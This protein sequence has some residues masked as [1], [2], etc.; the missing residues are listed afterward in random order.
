CQGSHCVDHPAAQVGLNAAVIGE[1]IGS[2]VTGVAG[3]V[4]TAGKWVGKKVFSAAWEGVKSAAKS[5]WNW[6]KGLFKRD[7]KKAAGGSAKEGIYEFNGQSGKKYV[8]QS[9]DIPKRVAQHRRSGKL[10]DSSDV[11]TT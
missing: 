10:P 9:G 2:A 3:A 5:A 11:K 7:S 1:A 6:A 8:G 4:K